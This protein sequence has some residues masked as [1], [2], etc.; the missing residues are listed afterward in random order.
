MDKIIETLDEVTV[1]FAGDSGDGIQVAGTQ[2]SDTSGIAGNEV[3]T[4]PDY[5]S[6]I[7]APEG[8]LYGVSA[9]QI[10]FGAKNIKTT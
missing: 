6:E 3:N 5:P 1:R 10:H 9:F 2:F 8:T 7:R 4:F